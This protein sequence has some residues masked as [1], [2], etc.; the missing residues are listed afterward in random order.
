MVQSLKQRTTLMV[1]SLKQRTLSNTLADS[2]YR[3]T[4]VKTSQKNAMQ[5]GG[6]CGVDGPTE[7]ACFSAAFCRVTRYRA[8][9]TSVA[10]YILQPSEVVQ[11]RLAMLKR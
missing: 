11:A 9:L 1:Q 5:H 8:E 10:K 3:G 4:R 7:F 2:F 6:E